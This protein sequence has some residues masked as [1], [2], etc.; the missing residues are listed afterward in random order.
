MNVAPT[1]R[2]DSTAFEQQLMAERALLDADRAA[3]M[4]GS[5]P[6]AGAPANDT[7]DLL[8]GDEPTTSSAPTGSA[9]SQAASGL[10][11]HYIHIDAVSHPIDI[12]FRN[13]VE[14]R[15]PEPVD[16]TLAELS[17]AAYD[18]SVTTVGNDA[19]TR[20]TDTQLIE[21]GID[22]AQL[23][24]PSTGFRAGIYTDGDGR[25]VLAFSG[26][27]TAKDWWTDVKQGVGG[28][29]MQYNEAVALAR[30][31]KL[32]FG[33]DLVLTGHSLGGGLASTAAVAT[34]TVA[35]TF[36]PAGVHAK[37]LERNGLDPAA[38]HNAAENGLVRRYVVEGE[39]L[40]YMQNKSWGPSYVMPDALGHEIALADPNPLNTIQS[41][42]PGWRAWHSIQLHSMNSVTSAMDQRPIFTP[43][44]QGIVDAPIVALGGPGDVHPELE[45]S[46]AADPA[47]AFP[48]SFPLDDLPLD[49][50]DIAVATY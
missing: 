5:G 34:D 15:T 31:A 1:P 24:D 20:L 17:K 9:G 40:D 29:A 18:P 39:A 12:S 19:W 47:H 49:D 30:D 11:S 2:T 22:P 48:Q 13:E 38:A 46:H 26:T 42:V 28:N 7:V 43:P 33:D 14:G 6:A 50:D 4:A 10:Q 16:R 35:V 27:A 36:N 25:H 45:A 21:A 23:E 44:N 3:G 8:A 32:A 37:T 41:W